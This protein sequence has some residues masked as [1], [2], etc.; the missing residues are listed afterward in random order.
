MIIGMFI[1]TFLLT[2]SCL[3]SICYC[4]LVVNVKN[5]GGDVYRENIEANTTQDTIVLEF[6]KADGTIVTQFVDGRNVRTVGISSC[7]SLTDENNYIGSSIMTT[8]FNFLSLGNVAVV[9]IV[10]IKRTIHRPIQSTLQGAPSLGLVNILMYSVIVRNIK[11]AN[12]I[13]LPFSKW[14]TRINVPVQ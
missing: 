7:R 10:V 3:V 4:Q 12:H 5:N 9:M 8:A 6:R 13:L 14:C 11:E 1:R 2:F